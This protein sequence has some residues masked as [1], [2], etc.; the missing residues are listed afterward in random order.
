MP[1]ELSVLSAAPRRLPEY[2]PLYQIP[3][4]S[5]VCFRRRPRVALGM[6][7]SCLSAF[8]DLAAAKTPRATEGLLRDQPMVQADVGRADANLRR[9]HGLL[10]ETVHNVWEELNAVG[11]M[12]MDQRAAL[13]I[14]ATHAIRL[15]GGG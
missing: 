15:A 12:S 2:G 14:A 11:C 8:L 6:A 10:A 5:D 7:R 3:A 13:R 9:G 1:Q 4:H